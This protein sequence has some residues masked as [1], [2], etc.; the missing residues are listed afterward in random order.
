VNRWGWGLLPVILLAGLVVMFK[1]TDP[2]RPFRAAFPPVEDLTIE[3]VSFPEPGKVA[4]RVVN[5]GPEPVTVAQ[6]LVDDA[7]WT[8]SA[9]PGPTVARL[10]SATFS[11]DYPWVEGEPHVIALLT[12][13]GLTFEHEVAVATLSP[14]ANSR[15]LATFA[16]LGAYAGI[17]PV[18]LGL[19]WYPFLRRVGRQW[20]RFYLCFTVGLLTFLAVD[21]AEHVLEAALGVPEGFQGV[22]LALLGVL[23]AV[24]VLRAIGGSGR[25]RRSERGVPESPLPVA[26]L[27]A[28]G[29]G[30][31]NFG[32][33]LAIGSA[34]A[35]GEIALGAFLVIGFMLH[36]TTEGLAIVAPVARSRP[37]LRHFAF[38]GLTA[39]VPTVIGAWAGGFSFSPTLA[40]F[41]LAL[42]LGAILQV[43]GQ[44]ARLVTTD[45]GQH[46]D[47]PAPSL[48]SPLNAAGLALGAV[49]MYATALAVTG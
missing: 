24:V 25:R 20:V 30:L 11:L 26:Y 29:I 13:T 16:A 33:G 14:A 49:V 48:F 7:F 46:A 9:D 4:V 31:H 35:L 2:T 47:A 21:A 23:G 5:G 38:M 27:V 44:V 18:L 15:Y 40:T 39:G 37:R 43:V 3:R 41:L 1:V 6:V 10:R 32:E 12:S 8:F 28:V 17:V 42:G 36:N 45:R 22:G 34:Y 19:L